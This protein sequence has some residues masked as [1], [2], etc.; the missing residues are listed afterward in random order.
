[1]RCI[2]EFKFSI[3]ARSDLDYAVIKDDR[4]GISGGV[5]FLEDCPIIFRSSTL[6]FLTLSVTE[7]ESAAGVMV[8][9][10]MLYVY[11][12]LDCI[13]LSL[14]LLFLLEMDN[15]GVVEYANNWSGEGG[16]VIWMYI[17][18][19]HELKDEGMIMVRHVSRYANKADI[20]M[21]NTAASVFNRH[22]SKFVGVDKYMEE[23]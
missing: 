8:A 14:E 2:S 16:L 13:G 23:R 11:R 10:D 18:F 1:M 17:Y 4:C 12:L 7:T 20:F 15:K 21:K 6:K 22:N 9:Q 19:L 3:H 5:V